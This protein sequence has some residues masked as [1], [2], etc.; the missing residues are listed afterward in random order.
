[1][2][3]VTCYKPQGAFYVFPN[4]RA[5]YGKSYNGRVV[6]DSNTFSEF[7]LEEAK[8]AVVPGGGFGAD[9]YVRLSF[10]ISMDAIREGL[11]RMERGIQLLKG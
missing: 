4:V 6:T 8:V 3:G 7:L 1:V 9:D 2:D 5:H 11:D 10:A